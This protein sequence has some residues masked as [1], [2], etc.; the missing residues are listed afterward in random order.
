M[1]EPQV[2]TRHEYGAELRFRWHLGIHG[3][4]GRRKGYAL[5]A[6]AILGPVHP[7]FNV[8]VMH[9]PLTHGAIVAFKVE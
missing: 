1:H 9:G 5:G 3:Y 2:P 6:H 8:P 4:V 7:K